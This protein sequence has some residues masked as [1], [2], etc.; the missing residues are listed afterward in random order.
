MTKAGIVL[1]S[2]FAEMSDE[3]VHGDCSGSDRRSFKAC[4]AGCIRQIDE[5]V[6][7]Y[8]M[9]MSFSCRK[10]ATRILGNQINSRIIHAK[11]VDSEQDG[12]V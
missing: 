8:Q 11:E 4:E 5:D 1:A 7:K 9:M 3:R 2:P 10:I 6:G 12:L